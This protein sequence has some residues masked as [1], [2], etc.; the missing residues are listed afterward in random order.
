M[1]IEVAKSTVQRLFN[2]GLTLASGADMVDGPAATQ[3]SEAIAGLDE[4][5]R[6]LRGAI[7]DQLRP[8]PTF[9]PGVSEPLT[10]WANTVIVSELHR[11]AARM[12]GLSSSDDAVATLAIEDAVEAVCRAGVTLRRGPHAFGCGLPTG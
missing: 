3:V 1:P 7:F 5:I 8:R 4:V 11:L 9:Q 6:D 2:L 10:T 12:N